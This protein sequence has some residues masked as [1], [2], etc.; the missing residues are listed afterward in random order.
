[1]KPKVLISFPTAPSN[2]RLHKHV[3]FASWRILADQRYQ[4]TPIISSH[5]PYENNLHHIILDFLKGGYD[6]WLNIDD[7]N[8]PY[9]NPLDLIELNKDIIGC[10]TPVRHSTGKLGERPVYYNGYVKAEDGNGGYKECQ[11]FMDFSDSSL[12]VDEIKGLELKKSLGNKLTKQQEKALNNGNRLVRVDA[13]GSGCMLISRRV[14]DNP[15]MQL[16]AFSR[17]LN[18]DGTVHKGC[19]IMF[20]ERATKQGFE[21]YAHYGYPCMHFNVLELNETVKDFKLLYGD[22]Q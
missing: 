21:I 16:G 19:D 12:T 10:I 3:V 5:N 20:C 1:M 14:L 11:A 22:T 6:W 18:K 13:I 9:G 17:E 4:I 15:A 7:D 8:P 2:P